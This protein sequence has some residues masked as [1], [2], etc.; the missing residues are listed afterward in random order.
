MSHK[1]GRLSCLGAELQGVGARRPGT[2]CGQ[3]SGDSRS[4]MNSGPI[5]PMGSPSHCDL[6]ISWDLVTYFVGH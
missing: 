3:V 5:F 1:L 4:G 6:P 2:R